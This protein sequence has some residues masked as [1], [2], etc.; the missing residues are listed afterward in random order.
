[1]G[2]RLSTC[3]KRDKPSALL[4]SQK[5]RRPQCSK[6]LRLCTV[7]MINTGKE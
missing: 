5:E 6:L 7:E 3:E 4:S 2:G 1:M